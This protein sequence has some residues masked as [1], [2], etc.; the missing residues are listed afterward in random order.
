MSG[1]VASVASAIDQPRNIP[2]VEAQLAKLAFPFD[3][4]RILTVNE[5]FDFEVNA[6]PAVL[7]SELADEVKEFGRTVLFGSPLDSRLFAEHRHLLQFPLVKLLSAQ[8]GAPIAH[9]S[10][11]PPGATA[12]EV[13]DAMAGADTLILGH[14]D[15]HH[16]DLASLLARVRACGKNVFSLRTPVGSLSTAICNGGGKQGRGWTRWP[17]LDECALSAQLAAIPQAHIAKSQIPVL[18]VVHLGSQRLGRLNTELTL[19]DVLLRAGN[20]IAQIGSAPYSELFGCEYSYWSNCVSSSFPAGL[21]V[22]FSKLLVETLNHTIPE[23][24]LLVAGCDQGP[25]PSSF[26]TRDFFTSYSVPALLFLFGVQPD[27]V[28]AVID[29]M[30]D[31]E[32]ACRN[33]EALRSLLGCNVLFVLHDSPLAAYASVIGR[34]APPAAGAGSC[35]CCRP[36]RQALSIPVFCA[37]TAEFHDQG[38]G[39]VIQYFRLKW[40]K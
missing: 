27:G 40:R 22:A 34:P 37:E 38:V 29:E 16:V 33:V 14:V 36:M 18:A 19:R 17:E 39:T 15:Q 2:S 3:S 4:A 10:A 6:A 7:R 31:P 11:A 35:R 12:D 32:L 21:R 26:L 23:A 8:P 28:I 1:V 9:H 30:T 24:A 20:K 5:D 13:I 25:C